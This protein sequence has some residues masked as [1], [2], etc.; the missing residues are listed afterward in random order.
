VFIV[1]ISLLI[2]SGNFWIHPRRSSWRGTTLP[3]S[4]TTKQRSSS[5]PRLPY[6]FREGYASTSSIKFCPLK[7]SIFLQETKISPR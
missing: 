4:T 6:G 5:I 7:C 1:V 2:Q 3:Y